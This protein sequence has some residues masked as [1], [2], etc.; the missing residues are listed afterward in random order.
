MDT[1]DEA[2][3]RVGGYVSGQ[4]LV[5]LIAGAASFVFF[6][7][8][9]VPHPALLALVVALFDA[10]PQIGAFLASF[11]GTVVAL[12]QSWGLGV[13]T[14]A[15]CCAYQ[16]AENYVIAPRVFSA[17]GATT[18]PE[19]GPAT[20]SRVFKTAFRRPRMRVRKLFRVHGRRCRGHDSA[21]A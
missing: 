21:K 6:L 15:F 12:S 9:G 1:L 4:V 3:A 13:A 7:V 17:S 11:I 20:S 2:L 10:L 19:R 16:A 14:L 18:S 8:V 5:S